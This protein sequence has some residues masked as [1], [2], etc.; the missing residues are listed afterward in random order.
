[1]LQFLHMG[2]MD[3]A[4]AQA[5]GGLT[6]VSGSSDGPPT[7]CAVAIADFST[8]LFTASAIM[9]ALVHR[10]RTGEG[11]TID[12]SLQECMWLLTSIEFSPIYFLTG[13]EPPRLGNGHP[14]MAPGNLYPAIDG[15]VII[16]TGVLA[17]VKR[18]Y[19]V[20]GRE[21]LFDTPLC[22]NQKIRYQ[23]KA[24]I[25]ALVGDWTKNQKADDI[26]RQLM[27]VDVPCARVPSFGEVCNDPQLLN[28][29]MIIDVEQPLSGKVR[30]PGSPYKMSK[31]PGDVN[32]HSPY[33][34]ENNLEIYSEMLGYSQEEI[35]RLSGS[36]II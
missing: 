28:R 24:E 5:L 12:I 27:S 31:T 23:H 13:K 16:S 7:K 21:D 30:V 20:M 18:L 35:D 3:H 26:V 33:L 11:Q 17:Q 10:D 2:S 8:G 19:S 36:G 32:H 15:W 6:A 4:V 22:T 1:M 14:A 9:A 34:G 29:N 25:D